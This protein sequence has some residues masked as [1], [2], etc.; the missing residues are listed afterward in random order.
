MPNQRVDLEL[1][2]V[3]GPRVGSVHVAHI[4][5]LVVH[6]DGAVLGLVDAVPP[7]T[8]AGRSPGVRQ[9]HAEFSLDEGRPRARRLLLVP[10]AS[11]GL[12]SG[13]APGRLMSPGEEALVAPL[14]LVR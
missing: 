11:D 3:G 6:D 2:A 12:A 14:P 4:G 10:E 7:S 9:A 5:G 13:L 8:D 1:Q